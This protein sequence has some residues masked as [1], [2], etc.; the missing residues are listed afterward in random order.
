MKKFLLLLILL[1]ACSPVNEKIFVANEEGGSVSVIDVQKLVEIERVKLAAMHGDELVYY[2]PHNVQ[3]VGDLVLITANTGAH[4]EE[5]DEHSSH[6]SKQESSH[7]DSELSN[8][9]SS[10]PTGMVLVGAHGDE[11]K[12]EHMDQLVVLD[13]KSHEVIERVDLGFDAHLAHVVADESYAYVT[14]TNTDELFKVNLADWSVSSIALPKGSSSHGLRLGDGFAAIAAMDGNL[15]IVNLKTNEIES[16]NVSGMLVQSAVVGDDVFVSVFDSDELARYNVKSKKLNKFKMGEAG[17]IQ[18][19]PSVDGKFIYVADQG[20]ILGKPV[21]SLVF[22]VDAVSGE[23]VK[24]IESGAAPHGVVVSPD[25][26]VWVTNLLDNTVSVLAED[27]LFKTI[28]V[29]V[30]PNGISYWSKNE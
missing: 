20:N 5:E 27:A 15:L 28:N 2:S 4:D 19:Y 17:P 21:G 26:R 29:G 23:I 25:G 30:A 18:L 13:A 24:S 7:G 6:N 16:V 9:L 1:A 8:S 22:K 3:V 12:S 11:P 14:S 10:L